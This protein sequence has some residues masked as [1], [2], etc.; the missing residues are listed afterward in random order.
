MPDA[1]PT[2]LGPYAGPRT[3]ARAQALV[4]PRY[5]YREL[6][7]SKLTLVMLVAGCVMPVLSM[8]VI[9]LK[10]NA[11]FLSLVGSEIGSEIV[12][13]MEMGSDFFLGYM[14][15]QGWIAIFLA[16]WIGPPLIARDTQDN[17]LPLYLSRP[18]SRAGYVGGKLA[19]L[20]GPLS[21]VTWGLGLLVI[22]FLVAFEGRGWLRLHARDAVAL[23]LGSWAL[24]LVLS[25]IVLAFSAL[26]RRRWVARG[27]LLGSILVLRG[28]GEAVNEILNTGW[29]DLIAP[30]RVMG[31]VWSGLFGARTWLAFMSDRPAIPTWAAWAMLA[32]VCGLATLVL[33][34]R[35]HAYE[36]SR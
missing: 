22:G 10:H 18:I 2:V 35:I 6:L 34:R 14:I 27:A 7:R 21:L 19:V 12:E 25:L 32:L 9:Y 24:I 8:I 33:A 36:V 31:A 5:G 20:L 16:L 11:T 23:M 30:T 3:R 28:L 13:E 17:A 29:G 26:V 1:A 15:F 4:I